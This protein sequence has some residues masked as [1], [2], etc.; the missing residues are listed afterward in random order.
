MFFEKLTTSL[1][2]A[3][4]TYEGTLIVVDFDIDVNFD[5]PDEFCDL[6]NLKNLIKAETSFAKKHKLLIHL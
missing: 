5:K 2:K 4:W 6:F 3:I 1:I